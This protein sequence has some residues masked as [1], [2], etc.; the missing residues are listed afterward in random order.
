MYKNMCTFKSV[1]NFSVV[2]GQVVKKVGYK[3]NPGLLC[4]VPSINLHQVVDPRKK[5]L[6]D[7]TPPTISITTSTGPSKLIIRDTLPIPI[8]FRVSINVLHCKIGI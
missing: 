2:P 7:Y 6:L 3:P 4:L 8:L 1:V 5:L